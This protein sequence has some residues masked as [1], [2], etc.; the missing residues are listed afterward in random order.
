[1][2]VQAIKNIIISS[3]GSLPRNPSLDQ[4]LTGIANR[5]TNIPCPVYDFTYAVTML[6]HDGLNEQQAMDYIQEVQDDPKYSK[7]PP[8]FVTLFRDICIEQGIAEVRTEEEPETEPEEVSVDTSRLEKE[9]SD[10]LVREK[11]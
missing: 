11:V 3:G 2:D 4:A 1:M 6:L 9:I 5:F 7:C 8:V 10:I